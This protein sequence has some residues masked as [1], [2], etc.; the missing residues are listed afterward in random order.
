M[1]E[2]LYLEGLE[3]RDQQWE[4]FLE[5]NCFGFLYQRLVVVGWAFFHV[6]KI[7]Y[8]LAVLGLPWPVTGSEAALAMERG[9][10]AWEALGWKRRSSRSVRDYRPACTWY[11]CVRDTLELLCP[12]QA[13][14]LPSGRK[15]VK[16]KATGRDGVFSPSAHRKGGCALPN[17]CF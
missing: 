13:Q 6:K 17:T 16:G 1:S 10:T 5:G 3:D 15:A 11:L 14:V 2:S 8:S 9:L 12:R 7:T 4:G